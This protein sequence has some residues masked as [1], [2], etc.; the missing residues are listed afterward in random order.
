MTSS[1]D[2]HGEQEPIINIDRLI[3]E[4]SRFAIMSY[5]YVVESADYV[6]LMR[7]TGF[8]W[9]NLASH[10]SKLES[11]GYITIEKEFLNKKPHTM[12]HLTESGRISFMEYRQNM[13]K[14]LDELPEQ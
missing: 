7:Q 9:G 2:N 14:V 11:A 1:K 6:F 4:P 10:L 3:H 12:I 8:T 13:R 5:L